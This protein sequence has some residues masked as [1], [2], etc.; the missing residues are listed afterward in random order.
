MYYAWQK[1]EGL[2][3]GMEVVAT[4]SGISVPVGER[5]LEDYLMFLE[6]L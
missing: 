5:L 1:S 6:I 4:G 2:H 3:K